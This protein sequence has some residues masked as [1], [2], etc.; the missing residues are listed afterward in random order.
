MVLILAN[1]WMDRVVEIQDGWM[2]RQLGNA[3]ISLHHK[4]NNTLTTVLKSPHNIQYIITIVN[5]CLSAWWR[6][7]NHKV[8]ILVSSCPLFCGQGATVGAQNS[9]ISHCYLEKFFLFVF[10]FE[11]GYACVKLRK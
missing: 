9:V 11:C 10:I 6:L 2:V 7:Y 3:S 8:V 4:S 5:Y 1:T